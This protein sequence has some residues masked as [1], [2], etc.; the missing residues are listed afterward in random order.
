[1]LSLAK[2]NSKSRKKEK[3]LTNNWHKNCEDWKTLCFFDVGEKIKKIIFRRSA[4]M[5]NG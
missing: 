5:E 3:N 2:K 1:M 4:Q